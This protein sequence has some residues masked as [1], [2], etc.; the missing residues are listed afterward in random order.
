MKKWTDLF[1]AEEQIRSTVYFVLDELN[2][3]PVDQKRLAKAVDLA[4]EAGDKWLEALK[5]L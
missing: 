2:K 3:N 1:R 5:A 4:I